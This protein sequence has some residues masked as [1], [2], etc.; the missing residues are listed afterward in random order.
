MTWDQILWNECVRRE[1]A[2]VPNPC[3][4]IVCTSICADSGKR[5]REPG[6]INR[7]SR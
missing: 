2:Y 5:K 3:T 1:C 4:G 7:R 6:P